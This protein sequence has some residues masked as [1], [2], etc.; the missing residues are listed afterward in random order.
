MAK[1]T[2]LPE[3]RQAEDVRIYLLGL[4]K[5]KGITHE[6]MADYLGKSTETKNYVLSSTKQVEIYS[7]KSIP[8]GYD[9]EY[10]RLNGSYITYHYKTE[11]SIN[12]SERIYYFIFPIFQ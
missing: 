8:S 1:I 4:M 5:V 6:Q 9:L 3:I 2:L 12:S 7:P 10:I 11:D